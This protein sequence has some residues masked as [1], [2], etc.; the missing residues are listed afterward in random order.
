MLHFLPLAVIGLPWLGAAVIWLAGDQR[1]RLLHIL[2]VAFSVLTGLAALGMLPQASSSPA[3]TIPLGGILGDFTLVP[4]GLGV[5]IAVIAAVVGSLAVIFATDYMRGHNEQLSRFYAF[6]LFFIGAMVGLGLS[7]S[8]LFTFFFWEITAL[9][10]YALISF[11]ND[12]PSAVAGGVKALIITQLGGVGLLAGSLLLYSYQG[13]Y[14]INQFLANSSSVPSGILSLMAF[15]CLIAAAAKSAQVPFHTWLPDAMEAP[16]PVTALIH[17]ATMV[18]AGVYLL[19]RFYPAFANVPGWRMAVM[20]VGAASALL[21][22]W[23]ALAADDIKRVLAY[24]TISQLGFMVYAVGSGAIFASQFHL[25]SHAIFKALLFLSAGALITALGTR[26]LRQMGGLG[27]RMPFVQAVFVI[28]ALGLVGLPIANG[29]FSKDLVLEGG[30]AGGPFWLYLIMLASVVLTAC[31]TLRLFRLVF[32]G[33]RRGPEPA[34]DGLP[35]MRVSLSI[36]ALATL[37]SW[38]LAGPLGKMLSTTLPF[39]HLEPESTWG[40]VRQILLNPATYIALACIALGFA[41]WAARQYFARPA[42]SLKSLAERGLGFEWI[43]RQV[44]G[45]IQRCAAFL[46]RFQTGQLN[47]NIVGLMSGLIVIL[48]LLAGVR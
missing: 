8:L 9:C 19:A 25:L 20:V 32:S 41:L 42:A 45:I 3:L 6:I 48:L 35:A 43:N 12:D 36:L 38:L 11:H 24:S 18:N 28:G 27:K 22:G 14:Q 47:W 40:L 23:M 33:E 13:N 21:A 34:H 30:L 44:V 15:G 26:D 39:H 17:A 46:Q 16:T 29:F 37:T 10:S 7:G 2:A 4:D 1:P 5:F 31:Y